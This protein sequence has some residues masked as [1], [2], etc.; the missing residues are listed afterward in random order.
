MT[1]PDLS[2]VQLVTSHS[3]RHQNLRSVSEITLSPYARC[4]SDL[5]NGVQRRELKQYILVEQRQGARQC[6]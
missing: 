1:V 3:E 6:T 4:I 2:P 5:Y